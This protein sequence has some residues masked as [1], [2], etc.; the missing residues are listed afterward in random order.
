MF[1]RVVWFTIGT[2]VGVVGA[3]RAERA[4]RERVERLAPANVTTSVTRAAR[5]IG[6]ELRSAVADGRATMQA[7]QARL[8]A[9]FDPDAAGRADTV[10]K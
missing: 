5:G 8:E 6:G 4:V 2:A 3:K 9:G 7:E 1:K 10:R